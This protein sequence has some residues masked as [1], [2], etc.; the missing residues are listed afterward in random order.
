[1]VVL[2]IIT[3]GAIALVGYQCGAVA[4]GL[5]AS[6]AFAVHP[7][8]VDSYSAALIDMVAACFSALTVVGYLAIDNQ[9]WSQVRH[10]RLAQAALTVFT[11]LMLACACGSKMNALTVAMLGLAMATVRGLRWY[12]TRSPREG[13]S[14]LLLISA[15][16]LAFL[17]FV[18]A[19]P[20]LHPDILD[21]LAAL[22]Y[23]HRQ[24]FLVQERF[25]GGGRLSTVSARIVPLAQ[26]VCVYPMLFAAV[27]LA[28]AI[29]A[30]M[31]WRQGS[32]LLVVIA[33]WLITWFALLSW[34][35]FPAAR[36]AMPLVTPTLLIAGKTCAD[37]GVLLWRKWK[38]QGEVH[39]VS[40]RA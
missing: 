21:G 17:I 13:R 31:A 38:P 28:V 4:G 3:A 15:L 5:L 25:L 6:L 7:V 36:Y 11:G 14:S 24:A 12:R 26:L 33:W 1:M 10:P 29:Q 37:L 22:F 20:T 27:I 35:P 23:E 8:V 18:A 34:L 16:G 19:N 30:R 32:P 9:G 39:H 2:A 40:R